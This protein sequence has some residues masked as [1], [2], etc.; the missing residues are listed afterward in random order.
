M[1]SKELTRLLRSHSW[2]EAE[3]L[4]IWRWGGCGVGTYLTGV[5]LL[6]D[7][8]ESV[9]RGLPSGL[10][11]GPFHLGALCA[12]EL[13]G[14]PLG[15]RHSFLQLRHCLPLHLIHCLFCKGHSAMV[16]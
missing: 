4:W 8:G 1:G 16:T 13:V 6:V 7:N 3:W 2:E 9:L 15:I 12:D 14:L 10:G 11:Q 5:L